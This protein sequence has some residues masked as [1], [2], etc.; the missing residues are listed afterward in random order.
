MISNYF[1]KP[2]VIL[3][4]FLV[5]LCLAASIVEAQTAAQIDEAKAKLGTMTPVL[6]R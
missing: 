4:I 3:S 2:F 1:S 6:G 5:S